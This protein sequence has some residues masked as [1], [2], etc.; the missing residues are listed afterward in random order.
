MLWVNVLWLVK[1]ELSS[2]GSLLHIPFAISFSSRCS[3]SWLDIFLSTFCFWLRARRVPNT[4]YGMPPMAVTLGQ[5][6]MN[7]PQSFAGNGML[8]CRFVLQDL[9]GRDYSQPG[10]GRVTP[11]QRSTR[12]RLQSRFIRPASLTR[13]CQLTQENFCFVRRIWTHEV[14][15]FEP[16]SREITYPGSGPAQD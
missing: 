9:R 12:G 10:F 13:V 2:T 6:S 3:P 7:R 15:L 11:M 4:R 1:L 5:K 16:H 14:S 8:H